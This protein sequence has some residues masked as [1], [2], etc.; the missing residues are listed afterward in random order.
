[1]IVTLQ[2]PNAQDVLHLIRAD[3]FFS[4]VDTSDLAQRQSLD[5][6]DAYH[7]YW[8][9]LAANGDLAFEV[10]VFY[11]RSGIAKFING[12]HRA[13]LLHRHLAAFPMAV[14]DVDKSAESSF[15]LRKI[16]IREL[17][18]G[19]RFRF[20]DLPIRYLGFDYNLG[21]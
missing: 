7:K 1:M 17:H 18:G 3:L 5:I 8:F 15:A 4:I 16:S 2:Q 19:E 11:L 6:N 13:L 12:R 10:P 9:R 20:P 14:A 21:V